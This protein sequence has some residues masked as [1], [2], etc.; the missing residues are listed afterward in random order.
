MA[1]GSIIN[2]S[3]YIYFTFSAFTFCSYKQKYLKYKL[4]SLSYLTFVCDRKGIDNPLSRWL[5]SSYL[6]VQVRGTHAWSLA[7]LIP[8]FSKLREI[9]TL[10]C[11]IS[12]S[13][14]R[15]YNT[16]S[17]SSKKNFWRRCRGRLRKSHIPSTYHKPLSFH[18]TFIFL[19]FSSPPLH[20]CRFICPSSAVCLWF[21]CFLFAR[22]LFACLIAL[23]SEM[24]EDFIE[25]G[26]NVEGNVY[27]DPPDE[28]TTLDIKKFRVF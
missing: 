22:V 4:S 25:K 14:L 9:L 24:G 10:P 13:S 16:S 19:S 28:T 11:C 12:L 5:R 1:P 23:M 21:A 27:V 20:P 8:W 3:I 18:I 17:R 6:F 2:I 26:S 15:E 7:G